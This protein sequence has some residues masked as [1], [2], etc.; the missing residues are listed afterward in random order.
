M[1]SSLLPLHS[2]PQL[3]SKMLLLLLRDVQQIALLLLLSRC[4]S[5]CHMLLPA[6]DC[7]AI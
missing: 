4:G 6:A 3:L 2:Q 1:G 7:C 5:A